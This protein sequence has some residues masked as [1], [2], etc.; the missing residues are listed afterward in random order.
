MFE[1]NCFLIL[2]F[3]ALGVMLGHDLIPH[4]HHHHNSEHGSSGHCHNV[5]HKDDD[6]KKNDDTNPEIFFIHN[7]NGLNRIVQLYGNLSIKT[8]SGSANSLKF[9]TPDGF[10]SF[11]TFITCRQHSPPYISNF[12]TPD[13]SPSTGLRAPPGSIS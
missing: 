4:H 3:T 9:F 11:T 7:Q 2:L 10:Y 1:K 5:M 13:P 12:L 6:T 8:F